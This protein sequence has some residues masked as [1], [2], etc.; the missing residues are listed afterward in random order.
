MRIWTGKLR[1]LGKA[2]RSPDGPR[3]DGEEVTVRVIVVDDA[4]PDVDVQCGVD[5][6]GDPR[7]RIATP[8][9]FDAR[10]VFRALAMA[11]PEQEKA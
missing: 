9:E 5:R 7:W 11:Q 4:P 10:S 8:G 6:L 3:E 1:L 2:T